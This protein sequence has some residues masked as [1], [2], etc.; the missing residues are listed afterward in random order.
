MMVMSVSSSS[1]WHCFK[2]SQK[3][4]ERQIR[5]KKIGGFVVQKR[6]KS[7][8]NSQESDWWRK[9]FAN[10]SQPTKEKVKKFLFD[11]NRAPTKPQLLENEPNFLDK[12]PY[13]FFWAT[14]FLF[15]SGVLFKQKDLFDQ[16][17]SIFFY[18]ILSG[19]FDFF[20]SSCNHGCFKAFC[21]DGLEEKENKNVKK[22]RIEFFFW[23]NEEKMN[24]TKT[25]RF[26]GSNW[27][28][29]DKKWTKVSSTSGRRCARE[30]SFGYKYEYS[31]RPEGESL[32]SNKTVFV[33]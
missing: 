19:T 18:F 32:L 20:Y 8:K 13:S 29:S 14:I 16:L 27:S 9:L 11:E 33:L 2:L 10:F 25:N 17:L 23:E 12:T 22:K 21:A 31:W 28:N 30:V 7:E 6:E 5:K 24:K 15:F 26:A 4:T 3:I 1:S